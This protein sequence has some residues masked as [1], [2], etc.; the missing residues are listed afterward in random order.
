MS[1]PWWRGI[2]SSIGFLYMFQLF[3]FT[4]GYEYAAPLH[5]SMHNQG[6]GGSLTLLMP[7]PTHGETRMLCQLEKATFYF[8]HNNCCGV[9]RLEKCGVLS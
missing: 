8:L 1:D 5:K 9:T 2:K 7:G 6:V 3:F 4:M